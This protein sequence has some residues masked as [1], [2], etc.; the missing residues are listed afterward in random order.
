MFIISSLDVQSIYLSISQLL[1][2]TVVIS[3][4]KVTLER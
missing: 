4:G 2:H 3:V 1:S